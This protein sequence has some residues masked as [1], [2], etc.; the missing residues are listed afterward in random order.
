MLR[1]PPITEG[2]VE[3]VRQLVLS[4]DTP[5]QVV[6]TYKLMTHH[7]LDMYKGFDGEVD[8]IGACP[9]WLPHRHWVEMR[10]LK[11]YS[12]HQGQL[13]I[14][15]PILLSLLREKET[16]PSDMHLT[17]F[18][19]LKLFGKVVWLAAGG[20]QTQFFS[21]RNNCY[22]GSPF[23]LRAASGQTADNKF[24]EYAHHDNFNNT[25]SSIVQS[26]GDT[27]HGCNP[28]GPYDGRYA[29]WS[30]LLAI[31]THSKRI[32]IIHCVK[33]TPI[34]PSQTARLEREV[35]ALMR[36]VSLLREAPISE[37]INP[38]NSEEMEELRRQ[39]AELSDKLDDI[40]LM[41]KQSPPSIVPPV[42]VPSAPS[43]P[44]APSALV[45]AAPV[46]TGPSRDIVHSMI[47]KKIKRISAASDSTRR[48]ELQEDLEE[49]MEL[50]RST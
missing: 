25:A 44:P 23:A 5:F 45:H 29:S 8:D 13:D 48:E 2:E 19:S 11:L 28:Y 31:N 33:P 43:V 50:L 30:P 32:Y 18:W 37:R 21:A 26:F 3:E 40:Y 22:G 10:Y 35:D 38:S 39:A 14:Y 6:N 46:S 34:I 47:M 36:E 27:P 7:I 17:P 24:L 49:L 4:L 12:S 20:T 1:Y 9:E 42:T 41:I 16:A 15:R